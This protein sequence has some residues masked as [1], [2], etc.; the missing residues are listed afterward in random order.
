MWA[1]WIVNNA[2]DWITETI[3]DFLH[4]FQHAINCCC[5]CHFVLDH[6]SYPSHV[7]N[8]SN[9]LH[10][11]QT[12]IHPCKIPNNPFDVALFP[13]SITNK[14][15]NIKFQM[16][17]TPIFIVSNFS[18]CS[19]FGRRRLPKIFIQIYKITWA[20]NKFY[21]DFPIFHRW[22][23][24]PVTAFIFVHIRKIAGWNK[25]DPKRSFSR[26]HILE[27]D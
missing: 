24:F 2:F 1:K 19:I 12:H 5:L 20:S 18:F 13:V 23:F 9:I 22:L 16:Y 10:Y 3:S 11:T 4:D 15:Y 7:T 17:A 8:N 26:T 27:F 21:R 14:R 25:S 6:V